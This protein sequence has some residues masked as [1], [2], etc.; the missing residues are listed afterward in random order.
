MM[1]TY[2]LELTYGLVLKLFSQLHGINHSNNPKLITSL[3]IVT[4]F[5]IGQLIFIH[6]SKAS[7]QFHNRKMQTTSIDSL[8]IRKTK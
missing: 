4:V 3:I 8:I 7:Y 1:K 6:Q 5:L 2:H